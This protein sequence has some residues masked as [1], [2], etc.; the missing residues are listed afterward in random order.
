LETKTDIE[1]LEYIEKKYFGVL[2]I[3]HSSSKG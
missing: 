2:L 1:E 3:F